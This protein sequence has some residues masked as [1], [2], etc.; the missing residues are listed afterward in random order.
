[1]FQIHRWKRIP[2]KIS[3]YSYTHNFFRW[4]TV[5]TLNRFYTIVVAVDFSGWMILE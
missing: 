1:M 5:F 3:I 2:L 4:E